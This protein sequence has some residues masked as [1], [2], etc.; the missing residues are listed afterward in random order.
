MYKY[1]NDQKCE[2]IVQFQKETQ[3]RV[4]FHG[5]LILQNRNSN[6]ECEDFIEI[7]NGENAGSPLILKECGQTKTPLLTTIGSSVWIKFQSNELENDMGF[8]FT[9]TELAQS[10]GK[11]NL[12]FQIIVKWLLGL[13]NN[14]IN[15]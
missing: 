5:K 9:I 1:P 7:R 6:G 10:K 11:L 8:S 4:E 14:I 15:V 2:K 13:K 3:F 12:K